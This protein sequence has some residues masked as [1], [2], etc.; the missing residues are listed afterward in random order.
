MLL[1]LVSSL[2]LDRTE[3]SVQEVPV[4]VLT[5]NPMDAGQSDYTFA[6]YKKSSRQEGT[7]EHFL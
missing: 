7:E 4:F 3:S 6:W 5:L 2:N 1:D